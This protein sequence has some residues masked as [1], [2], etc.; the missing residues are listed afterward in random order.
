MSQQVSIFVGLVTRTANQVLDIREADI[1]AMGTQVRY[2]DEVELLPDAAL[3][4]V[5]YV[6]G[7]EWAAPPR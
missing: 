6:A 5:R 1:W 3:G 7:F 2:V 4:C